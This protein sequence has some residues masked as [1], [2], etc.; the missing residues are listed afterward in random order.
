[1]ARLLELMR[2]GKC[3][4]SNAASWRNEEMSSEETKG[5]KETGFL[6]ERGGTVSGPGPVVP[7][8]REERRIRVHI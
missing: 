5:T 7:S 6:R 2:E 4:E 8:A 1:M 3:P